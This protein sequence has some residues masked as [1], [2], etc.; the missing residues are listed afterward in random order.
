MKYLINTL[1]FILAF[2]LTMA[3]GVRAETVTG[4]VLFDEVVQEHVKNGQVDYSAIKKDKRF[5]EY[6]N[7]LENT[8]P[9]DFASRNAKLAFWINAYN[10]LTIKG[11]LD[12]LSPDGFF[13][14]ITFFKSTKYD[15]AGR[16]INLYDLERDIIIPFN[17][18]RIHFA[19]NCASASCPILISEAYTAD[20]LEKN[21]EKNAKVFI[22]DNVKNQYDLNQNQIKIS[23]IFDWFSE[24]FENHSGSVQKYLAKYVNDPT[25]AELLSK[26]SFDVSYLNYDWSLNGIAIN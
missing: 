20:N 8:N 23:K 25:I 10:A 4:H 11:I 13:S 2:T 7:Y 18:P 17:E 6:I 15:V 19:I 9:D 3:F 14:R 21:L 12:G 16:N 1:S 24:D 22:N 26:D 5:T